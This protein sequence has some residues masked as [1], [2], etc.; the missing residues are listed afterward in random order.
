MRVFIQSI[1][2]QLLLNPYICWRGYQ[3]L[4]AKKSWRIPYILFFILE[5]GLYFFGFI[6]RNV[7][8]DAWMTTIQYICNT[9]YI[10]S[11]YITLTLLVLETLRLSNRI[12][13][14]FPVYITTHWKQ[15]K[16]TVFFLTVAGVTGLMVQAYRAVVNPVVT[17]V[18]LTIPKPAG[19]QRDSLT[20]VMMSDLHIGEVI[21]KKLVQKYVALS[22]AQ[23]PDLVII[24]G[25]VMDYEVRFAAKPHIEEDLQQ[26]NAPL[27]VYIVNGNHEYRANIHE[28]RRWLRS[29]GGVLLMDSVVMPDSSFYLI[30]RDDYTNKKRATLHRLMEGVDTGKPVI[31]MDHQPWSLAETAMNGVDLGV[32]GHTHNGQLWPYPLLM[33]LIYE[34]PYGYCRKGNSQFYV[35]SGIGIAGPPY[36][37]GTVSELVVLHIRFG[38]EITDARI[39]RHKVAAQP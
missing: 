12:R 5:L 1:V 37:V 33:K 16:L 26:L 35:S 27:G 23:H 28:K 20:I 11:I 19:D 4:P 39:N 30:G 22:N 29:T 21:G 15:T 31:L 8:P 9:W 10:A 32:Y 2:A 14:W 38:G 18:Y 13:P 7:L 34:C 24:V 6:F 3:A 25:D 36:R 17:D